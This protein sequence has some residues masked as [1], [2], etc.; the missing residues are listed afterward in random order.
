MTRQHCANIFTIILAIWAVA[1]CS[2]AW[3]QGEQPVA[4]VD[5]KLIIASEIFDIALFDPE[6]EKKIAVS[7]DENFSNTIRKH[8]DTIKIETAYPGFFS[9]VKTMLNNELS[10][11]IPGF[12]DRTKKFGSGLLVKNMT[13]SE[14]VT[15]RDF[16]RTPTGLRMLYAARDS[17]EAASS[18]I[19][20]EA[21]EAE[22]PVIT[23]DQID[24][25]VK[26]QVTAALKSIRPADQPVIA[27][28][29][30][31]PAAR[32]LV[33]IQ[34]Q[35]LQEMQGFIN[36]EMTILTPVIQKKLVQ[37]VNDYREK[38]QK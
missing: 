32:K 7:V 27:K 5:Q 9:A 14:L 12:R 15:L 3:S 36:A 11:W 24:T 23:N 34:G 18:R 22:E 17:M 28:F 8:P 26:E 31:T 19:G 10:V 37:Y 30:Q 1:P 20:L 21:V 6:L 33:A 2:P 29:S 13:Q 16:Y 35:Y 4:T 38:K 25:L